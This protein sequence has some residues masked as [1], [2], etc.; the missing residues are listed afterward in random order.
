LIHSITPQLSRLVPMLLCIGMFGVLEICAQPL[1]NS[2]ETLAI[3]SHGFEL[4]VPEQVD[5][6]GGHLQGIQLL[7]GTLVVSGSSEKFA[8]LGLFEML[9]GAFRFVGIKKLA[10]DPLSHA[11][12]FQIADNWLA[13]GIE[14]PQRKRRSIVQLIDVSSFKTISAPPAHTLR[15]KGEYKLSTAGAVALVLRKDHFLLAVG[16]W[17]CTTIDFYKSNHLNPYGEDFRLQRWTSWDSRQAVRKNWSSK[18]Y[19]SYQN[20]QLTEDSTGLYITGFCRSTNGL[21]RADV[22]R[23]N[24]GSI[25]A[26]IANERRASNGSP[27][28]RPT[29]ANQ[30]RIQYANINNPY[31]LLQKVASY[32][33]QCSGEV[34]FRNGAGFAS[35]KNEPSIIA[36]GHDLYPRI[37]LQIFP[38]DI[39]EYTP[40][41]R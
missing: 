13:V 16:T 9:E 37:Q 14:D 28:L 31:E 18:T 33:V 35:Y 20:L 22:Y 1:P 40:A 15:R 26:C 3:E 32:S 5:L 11:G 36:V 24:T 23:L 17:D 10:E 21:D 2:K 38:I 12:G 27:D 30:P 41:D 7:N 4:A 25:E 29:N 8:Y 34:T 19:G 6:K 39:P